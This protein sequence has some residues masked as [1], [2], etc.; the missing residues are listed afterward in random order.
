MGSLPREQSAQVYWEKGCETSSWV[1]ISEI[2]IPIFFPLQ[3][4]NTTNHPHPNPTT[5]VPSNHFTQG[6]CPF[7]WAAAVEADFSW[8]Y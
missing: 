7:S 8:F 2:K 6:K 3:G 5:L 4:K 1:R